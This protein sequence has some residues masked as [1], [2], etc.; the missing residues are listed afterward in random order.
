MATEK[1][2]YICKNCG[3]RVEFIGFVINPN[4]QSLPAK[5]A[6]SGLCEFC[7]IFGEETL[8]KLKKIKTFA[9]M[10]FMRGHH[11]GVMHID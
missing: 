4:N 11:Q 9:E 7:Y 5:I 1:K 10:H 8:E 6:L 3:L 2:E